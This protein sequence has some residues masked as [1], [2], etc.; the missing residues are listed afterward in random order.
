MLNEGVNRQQPATSA[1]PGRVATVIDLRWSRRLLYSPHIDAADP[2]TNGRWAFLMRL[3]PCDLHQTGL[4][5]QLT[6]TSNLWASGS[7]GQSPRLTTNCNNSAVPSRVFKNQTTLC[8]IGAVLLRSLADHSQSLSEH[9]G[10]FKPYTKRT[11]NI[12]DMTCFDSSRS[13]VTSR[14]LPN[15]LVVEPQHTRC[16]LS[17][18]SSRWSSVSEA[19]KAIKFNSFEDRLISLNAVCA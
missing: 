10:L 15:L 18:G 17:R 5:W 13:L 16:V 11:S 2:A 9:V 8:R 3:S 12:R 6:P 1:A 7:H 19:L 4:P 14:K